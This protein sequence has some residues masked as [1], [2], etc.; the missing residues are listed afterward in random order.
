MADKKKAKTTSEDLRAKSPDE[1]N[2][3][4]IELK[5]QHMNMRFQK[6][7]GQLNNTAEMRAVRRAAARVNT[8]LTEKEATPATGTTAKAAPA[9]KKAPAKAKKT[10]A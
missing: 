1:L 5:K 6:A 8:I 3:M 10:A 9:K 7:G 4:L 2:K